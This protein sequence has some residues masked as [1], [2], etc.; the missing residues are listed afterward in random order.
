VGVDAG[1]DGA[2]ADVTD[3]TALEDASGD[4]AVADAGDDTTGDALTD[5][6][7]DTTGDVL[8]DAADDTTGDVL[9]D[10]GGDT[11]SDVVEDVFTPSCGVF[12]EL[13][14]GVP[15]TG[16]NAAFTDSFDS[17]VTNCG[18]TGGLDARFSVYLTPGAYCVSSIGSSI[19]TVVQFAN[20]CATPNPYSVCADDDYGTQELLPVTV[21]AAG[22][23]QV[24]LDG[25]DGAEIG[26]AT[27]V[28]KSGVCRQPVA[29][30]DGSLGFGALCDGTADCVDGSDELVSKCGGP[31]FVG[32]VGIPGVDVLYV[33]GTFC[34]GVRDC[35]SGS[36]EETGRCTLTC[37]NE[38]SAFG[39]YCDGIAQCLD[40]SDES[41]TNC[42]VACFDAGTGSVTNVA[43]AY[44]DGTPDCPDGGD[45][46]FG[47]DTPSLL[48]GDGV[49]RAGTECDL[50]N[51]CPDG[52]DESLETCGI[53]CPGS[54]SAVFGAFCDGLNDCADAS[55]EDPTFCDAL[56][57]CTFSETFVPGAICDGTPDCPAGEDEFR[58]GPRGE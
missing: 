19:D 28:V 41:L 48:C 47:C 24:V 55:D 35:S 49:Y 50:V 25:F 11:A 16:N 3:D 17:S 21:R 2:T 52:S 5:A 38:S 53:T 37:A 29:C 14:L 22:W 1:T 12:E 45:E 31:G 13:T 7:D 18:A 51:D 56:I 36:D 33:E 44:C 32:C 34:N 10:A 39:N 30:D 26:D 58:C 20:I 15:W 54:S 23:Y 40:G 4:D 6:A 9:T 42:G 27:L 57:F 43:G 46:A 8:T